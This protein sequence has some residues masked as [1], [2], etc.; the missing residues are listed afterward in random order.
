MRRARARQGYDKGKE[1]DGCN[2]EAWKEA[3]LPSIDLHDMVP[4]EVGV[5]PA[6][7]L[8]I[9]IP[10]G[11]L[12]SLNQYCLY[13]MARF[14]GGGRWGARRGTGGEAVIS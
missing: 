3:T 12:P 2:G 9:S 1:V 4:F 11:G 8:G 14:L 13:P 7:Q 6:G 5:P 10:G